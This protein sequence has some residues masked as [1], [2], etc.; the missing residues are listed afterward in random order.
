MWDLHKILVVMRP[1]IY[2][3]LPV[4]IAAN[5]DTSYSV[6]YAVRDYPSGGYAHS[7]IYSGVAFSLIE[8]LLMR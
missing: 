1:D 8:I 4:R 6:C 2:A 7:V 5:Y 3:P